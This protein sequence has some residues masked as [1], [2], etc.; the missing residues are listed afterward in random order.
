M[1]DQ[2]GILTPVKLIEVVLEPELQLFRLL[3]VTSFHLD[4]V[5]ISLFPD[6]LDD[7]VRYIER[8][9]TRAWHI[10]PLES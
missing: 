2:K 6:D 1:I 10:D 9:E 3:R 4:S 8:Q 5:V 7:S